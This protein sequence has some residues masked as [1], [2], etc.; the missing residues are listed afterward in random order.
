[1]LVLIL[2][3]CLQDTILSVTLDD[4]TDADR[5]LFLAFPILPISNNF[6]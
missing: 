2:T 1:M 6:L 5:S 4:L 3:V